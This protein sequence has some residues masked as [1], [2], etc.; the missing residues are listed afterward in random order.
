MSNLPKVRWAR[1]VISAQRPLPAGSPGARPALLSCAPHPAS[2][3]LPGDGLCH[4]LTTLQPGIPDACFTHLGHCKVVEDVRGCLG[5][6]VQPKEEKKRLSLGPCC[7]P[8][9]PAEESTEKFN[10]YLPMLC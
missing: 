2:S 1:V 8:R 10:I 6:G 5:S 7:S 9:E 3:R 4:G